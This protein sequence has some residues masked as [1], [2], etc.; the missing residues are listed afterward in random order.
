MRSSD[1]VLSTFQSIG[2]PRKRGSSEGSD[3]DTKSEQDQYFENEE[4][5]IKNHLRLNTF[6]Q[7]L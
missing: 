3:E 5:V 7:L 2:K 1:D 4:K 6:L